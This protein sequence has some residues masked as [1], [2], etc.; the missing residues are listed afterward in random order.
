MYNQQR[1]AKIWLVILFLLFI[2]M[3]IGGLAF[4][5][6]S[7]SIDRILPVLLGHGSL[8]EEFILFSVR[9]PRLL[10]LAL[11]GM[12]L[13][14]S[15]AL[16]QTDTRNDLAEPGIIGINAGAGVCITVFYL[17]VQSDIT[18]YAYILPLIGLIG[19]LMT[20][21]LIYLFSYERG[22]GIQPVKLVLIGVGFAAALSGLMMVM[23]S[24]AE[25]ADVQFIA[26]WLA[27]NVWGADWPFVYALL[28]W[29]M[30]S[31]PVVFLKVNRM[32]ILALNEP[33]AIGLG[34]NL[35]KERFVLLAVS[36]ACSS[37]A[38]A[39]TGGISFVG[40]IAPHIA[41][42]LVGPRHQHFLPV[43]LFAGASLLLLAD[44]IGR[45]LLAQS[46]IPAGIIVAII[47]AP[48]FIYLLRKK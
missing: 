12:A 27:G 36:V 24:S 35:K 11:A 16:L 1:K 47:G 38:V 19:A 44:T 17:Y 30:V 9:L 7:V 40:L 33:A 4:G 32:N 18:H 42:R 10:V 43:A 8:K 48:Y 31:L 13:A 25:R 20:A 28:P 23:I 34:V 3:A 22:R 41:K 37:A 45:S 14:L 2:A 6:S 15:G 5:Y 29:L 39:V 21:A 46:S 26:Q